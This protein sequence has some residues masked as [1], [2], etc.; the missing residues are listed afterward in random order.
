MKLPKEIYVWDETPEHIERSLNIE[1]DGAR[2]TPEDETTPRRAGVYQLVREVD[3]INDVKEIEVKP[4]TDPY[5]GFA[6]VL[7]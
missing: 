2:P 5:A 3:I 7:K 1:A 4:A 6:R